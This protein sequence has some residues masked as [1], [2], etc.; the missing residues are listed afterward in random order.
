M[1]TWDSLA[2]CW[3]SSTTWPQKHT[4]VQRLENAG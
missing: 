1:P 2:T 4:R 3:P